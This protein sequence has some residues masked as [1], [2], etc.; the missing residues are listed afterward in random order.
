MEQIQSEHIHETKLDL[1]DWIHL[2]RRLWHCLYLDGWFV[3]KF[4]LVP[5]NLDWVWKN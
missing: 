5:I 1:P 3:T 4:G 2:C